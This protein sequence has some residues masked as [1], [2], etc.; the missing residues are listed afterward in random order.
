MAGGLDLDDLYGL[1][2]LRPFYNSMTLDALFL[3]QETFLWTIS[4]PFNIASLFASSGKLERTFLKTRF[5]IIVIGWKGVVQNMNLNF[6]KVK[7]DIIFPN[8]LVHCLKMLYSFHWAGKG[9][10]SFFCVRTVTVRKIRDYHWE[11]YSSFRYFRDTDC[12]YMHFM[13]PVL[14]LIT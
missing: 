8:L 13:N 14:Q 9:E 6:I 2:Q 10:S 3:L 4:W 7:T 12:Y 5:K 11:N 1:F